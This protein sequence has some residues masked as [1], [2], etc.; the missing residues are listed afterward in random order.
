MTPSPA[1]PA[2]RI[3]RETKVSTVATIGFAMIGFI[4]VAAPWWAGRADLRLIAEF[5]TYLALASSW[6]LLA[7]Y[8][9]LASV[10]QQAFVGLG[11]YVLFGLVLIT[12]VP[13]LLALPVAALAGGIAATVLAPLLFRLYGAYFAIGT[14]AAAEVFLLVSS[15]FASLGGG[16][17]TNLPV[18]VLSSIAASRAMREAVLYWLSLGVGLGAVVMVVAILRSK[19]GLA[20]KAARD[21]EVA[22]NSLGVS[23]YRTKLFV[24]AATGALTALVGAIIFLQKLRIAPD[25][26]YSTNDWTAFVIFI[27]VIGGIGTIE[28]PILGA[29]LFFV[30]RE[31]LADYGPLYLMLLGVIAIVVML[32]A[33]RGIWGLIAARTGWQFIA[34]RRRVIVERSGS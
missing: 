13:P 21:S 18:S 23:T 32:K 24:Y 22:A 19:L 4:L 1:L 31:T 11:A 12:G 6:N 2:F 9:G 16:A 29:V 28:G 15:Q 5:M 17:G 10:G 3:V 7:G 25:S 20:L 33:P 30:L 8:A 26:A 34:V 27:V 14:W